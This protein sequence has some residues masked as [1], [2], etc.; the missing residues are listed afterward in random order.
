MMKQPR[1]SNLE[2]YKLLVFD[3][4]LQAQKNGGYITAHDVR[5]CCSSYKLDQNFVGKG[6]RKIEVL[7][8][9]PLA[10]SKKLRLRW[11]AEVP[12]DGMIKTLFDEVYLMRH[13]ETE[14]MRRERKEKKALMQAQVSERLFD[15][16]AAEV[17]VEVQVSPSEDAWCLKFPDEKQY[18]SAFG[19]EVM[20]KIGRMFCIESIKSELDG[21]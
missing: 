5:S 9:E 6:L 3:L 7:I 21:Q 8:P 10:K 2:T 14:R 1:Y 20:R 19:L 13:I 15:A 18:F 16:D 4:Y 17:P 12:N 11:A